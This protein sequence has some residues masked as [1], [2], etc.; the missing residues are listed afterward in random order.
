MTLLEILVVLTILAV[1]IGIAY[2]TMRGMNEHNKL[3]AT[4]R[5][6]VALIK[7]ARSEAVFGERRTQL[8]IDLKRNEFWLDLRT[9]D[10]KTGEYTGKNKN[11]FEQKRKLNE[12]IWFDEVTTYD[13]NIIKDKLIGLDFY[14]D[15]SASPAMLTLTN[16]RGSRMTVELIK[17]TA[18][19]EVTLGSIADKKEKAAAGGGAS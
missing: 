13:R 6:I 3:R 4:T 18:L 5:E 11:Q 12:N 16:K 8:F 14:P 7:Y 2:P 1:M 17:G 10:P 15:G 9:P 19:T